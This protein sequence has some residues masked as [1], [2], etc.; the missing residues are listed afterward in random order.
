MHICVCVYAYITI[1]FKN[2]LFWLCWVF[3]AT[4][5]FFVVV[6]GLP[7]LLLMGLVMWDHS[8]TD[9]MDV[10]LTKLWETVKDREAWLAAIHEVA[11]SWTWLS[12]WMT[13]ICPC[14]EIA[15]GSPTL[16]AQSTGPPG[17]SLHHNFFIHSSFDGC[18]GCFTWLLWIMLWWILVCKY[19]F[20]ILLWSLLSCIPGSD[21]GKKVNLKSSHS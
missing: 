1:S 9:S 21:V 17:K 10:N 6:C 4:C 2:Y 8:I 11:K 13:T 7:L 5:R 20:S 18:L 19:L 14:T 12:D 16:G 15:P 3:V